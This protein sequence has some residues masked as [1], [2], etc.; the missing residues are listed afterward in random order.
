ML[1]LTK[2]KREE[3]KQKMKLEGKVAIV[4]GGTSGIGEATAKAFAK[5]GSKVVVAGRDK[6]DGTRIVNEIKEDDGEAIF[7]YLD[8]TDKNEIKEAVKETIETFK[9]IDILY[10]GAGIHDSYKTVLDIDEEDY[11]QLMDVNVKGPF[12][13]TREVLPILLEKGKGTI[14]NVGS[15][16]TFVAGPGG[17]AY[18]TSKHAI[19]GFTKQLS[20]DFGQKGIKAN[21]IAPGFVETPMTEGIKDKRLNDIPAKRAGKANEIAAL[22]VFLASDESDYIQ[23]TSIKIDGGWTIGR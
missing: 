7:V 4:V 20:Y 19:E 22:S 17:S 10:N 14:I 15:Q 6:E 3:K 9:T 16:A 13:T 1:S 11:D 21:L 18:V 23:G 12:L 5:E 2:T 8:T